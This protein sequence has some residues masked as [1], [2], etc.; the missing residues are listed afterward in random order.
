MAMQLSGSLNFTGS[1]NVSGQSEFGGNIVPKTSKGA[2]LGTIDRPFADI[3]IQSA[4]I[5]IQ[6]DTAGQ[7][8]TTISNIGGNLLISAGGMRL[9]GSSSFI[10]ATGSFQYLSGS[11]THIGAQYNVG[12]TITTGSLGV[13]GSTIMIGNNTMTGNTSL[14]GSVNISGSTTIRGTTNFSDSST[15]ISGSFL[16]SG[17]TTQIGNNTLIGNT[18][19]SGSIIISGSDS[20]STPTI[21]VFGDMQTNGVIKFDP[22]SKTINNSISA[23]YIFV[24]GSTNDLYFS[25]NGNG[26]SNT[27]RLKWIEGNLYSGLLNGGVISQIDS[28]HYQV[29]SGSGILVT[30][31][32]SLQHEPYPTIQYLTWN[33]LSASIAPL[34]ASYLQT[35]VGIDSTGNIVSSGTPYTDGQLDTTITIGVVLHQNNSTINGVKTQPYP[36]YGQ[37]KRA[38]LFMQAFGPLKLNGY[39]LAPSGSSTG[40]LVVGAGSAFTIGSNYI[41]D[42]NNTSLVSEVGTNTSKIWRYYQTGSTWNFDTNGSNGYSAIDPTKYSNNGVLTTVSGNNSNQYQWTIQRCYWFPNSVAKSIVVYYGNAQYTS[43]DLAIA[44]LSTEVFTEAPNTAVNAIY[45]GAFILRKDAD[46]TDT[47]T[48][49]FVN[50]GL[51][52]STSAGGS[53]GGFA[54]GTSGT[55]GTSG[56]SGVSGTNGTAGSGGTSG[57]NGT[58]G[59]AGSGGTSGINGTNGTAGS[60]GTSGLNGSSGTS[61]T[62]GSTL[63]LTQYTG[64]VSISGSLTVSQTAVTNATYLANTSNLILASGSNLY[65]Y[66]DALVSISGSVQVTGSLLSTL[67]IT[68]PINA[69]NGVISSSAQLTG[70]NNYTGSNDS[71]VGKVLQTT[72]SL[73]TYTGSND[74][75]LSRILQTTASINTTTGSFLAIVNQVLQTTASLNTYTGSNNSLIARVLQTTASLNLYTASYATTGSNSFI[76]NQIVT[77]SLS[78]SGSIIFN[79]PSASTTAGI[80]VNGSDVRG[81]NGYLN[82]LQASNTWNGTSYGN[83]TFRIS[84]LGALEIIN[85]GYTGTLLSLTE[86]GDLNLSGSLTMGNRPGFRVAG[87]GNTI[88]SP[89]I[90]ASSSYSADWSQG[91]GWNQTTGKFTAPYAGLYQ[92]NVVC[93]ISGNTNPSAQIIVRK[94]SGGTIN[95]QIMLEWAANTTTNHMGGSTITKMAV[96]DTLYVEVTV[97]SISFDGNDSFSV[98]YIG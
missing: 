61:G 14:T 74:S 81:G 2:T 10:A 51:F 34:S 82:F 73:N 63:I 76:G 36:A 11:F 56:I 13:S 54:S 77:G 90:I 66:N 93:R 98:A 85:S 42:P 40:S 44:G 27:T 65:I 21:R 41:N 3:F 87:A 28:T 38:T 39:Q 4:S 7:P 9:L 32:A 75:L 43:Q 97:G 95:T 50:A 22:V 46:F 25:Q 18:V 24:S 92:V 64:S 67:G 96:G 8:N 31:N 70:L 48:Y 37:S 5:N 71:I 52:R 57:I 12:D 49:S 78:I 30:M 20:P 59:T 16:V 69:T 68:G 15:T 79:T 83:K 88:T 17:S 19:L 29:S 1:L 47:T 86:N 33:N 55:A 35:F 80:V 89:C 91:T 26:Y 23:S 84:S 60:G 45:L 72:A 58:H 6:S 94:N 53:I 62:N